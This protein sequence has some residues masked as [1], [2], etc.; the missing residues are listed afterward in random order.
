MN[1]PIFWQTL[2]S[3]WL[4]IVFYCGGLFLYSMFLT[5]IYPVARDLG[6]NYAEIFDKMPEQVREAMGGANFLNNGLSFE[7]FLSLEHLQFFWVI[8]VAAFII[9]FASRAIAG[10]VE[11]G[12]I[13]LLLSQPVTR[14]QIF[15]SK[16]AVGVIGIV[17]LVGATVGGIIWQAYRLD[18]AI[19]PIE[20]YWL[21]ISVAILFFV[22]ILAIAMMFS[23]MVA[24]RGRAT[25]LPL[26]FVI[27][28]FVTDLFAK[29][30]EDWEGLKWLS[31]FHYYGTPD[32]I[33]TNASVDDLHLW[34][35]AGIIVTAIVAGL[36]VFNRRDIA[37]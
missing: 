3:Y 26:L 18:I 15:F 4:T 9:G 36:V 21:F 35:F 23:T 27:A 11:Q 34:V 28:S 7:G 5:F 32:S 29:L 1:W 16:L 20:G 8:A 14:T 24:E 33:I 2:K 31:I 17:A 22:S 25:L 12:T 6:T 10:E 37:V 19:A 13:A 30:N